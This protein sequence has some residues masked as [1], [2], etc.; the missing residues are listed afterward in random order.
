MKQLTKQECDKFIDILKKDI[1]E[2]FKVVK[3]VHPKSLAL[4]ALYLIGITVN[5]KKYKWNMGFRKF[6]DDYDMKIR[7]V[8]EI[9]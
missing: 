4:D 6:L 9:K 3:N 1:N 2:S 8:N 7:G 5:E